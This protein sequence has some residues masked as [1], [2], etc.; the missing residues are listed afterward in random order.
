MTNSGAF[1]EA[2]EKFCQIEVFPDGKPSPMLVK[3]VAKFG[4]LAAE[5]TLRKYAPFTVRATYDRIAKEVLSEV[6]ADILS[7]LGKGS[8]S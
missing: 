8:K 2:A 3:M 5:A 7:R 4:Q 6:E 1:R